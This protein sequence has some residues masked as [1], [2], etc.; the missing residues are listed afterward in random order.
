MEF[1]LRIDR[2]L[3]N[4]GITPNKMIQD[5]G[6]GSSIYTHWK[7]RKTTPYGE[8]LIKTAEYF[9][10]SVDYLLGRTDFREVVGK[11]WPGEAANELKLCMEQIK[12]KYGIKSEDYGYGTTK[13]A[14]GQGSLG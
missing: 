2:L 8:T 12:R 14:S 1:L 4:R 7:K 10:V 6:F 3:A 13:G 9:G 5:L 11:G